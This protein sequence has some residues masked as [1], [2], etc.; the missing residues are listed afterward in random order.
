MAMGRGL[1][2]MSVFDRQDW[3]GSVIVVWPKQIPVT[4]YQTRSTGERP[5]VWY[6]MH[7]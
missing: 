4:V 5:N 3:A 2:R 1:K 7:S 6:C